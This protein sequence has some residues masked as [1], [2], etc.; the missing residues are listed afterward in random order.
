MAIAEDL[1][2][3]EVMQLLEAEPSSTPAAAATLVGTGPDIP[4]LRE[5]LAI[6]VSTGK[7][8]EAV[9][10]QLTHEE[11][12]RLTDTEVQKF[13]RR[14]ETYVGAKTTES[15]VDGFISV[16]VKGVGL[17]VP[18]KDA[19]SMKRDLKKDYLI[20]KELSTAVGHISLNYGPLLM[21]V[22]AALITA[23]HVDFNSFRAAKK[24]EA[25]PLE[26][27]EPAAE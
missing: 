18:L 2:M 6:L 25:P 22:N 27:N 26:V 12:R 8:K 7:S 17:F 3:A 24:N 19:E 20:E 21:A 9:G 23:K 14:Y 11:V 10:K 5:Q 4:A 13:Y 1:A 16:L 15:I